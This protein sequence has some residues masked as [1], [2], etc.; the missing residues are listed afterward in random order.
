MEVSGDADQPK[1]HKSEG[2]HQTMHPKKGQDDM[3][4]EGN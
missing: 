4:R 2:Q 3:D 1:H